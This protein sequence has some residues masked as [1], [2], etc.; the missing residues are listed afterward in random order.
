MFQKGK[1]KL[2]RDE[3]ELINVLDNR[4]E[5]LSLQRLNLEKKKKKGLRATLLH[6]SLSVLAHVDLHLSM[7]SE[8][9]PVVFNLA[10]R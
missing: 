6:K 5:N 2:A 9:V 3:R 7:C 4:M 8:S 1:K 10:M